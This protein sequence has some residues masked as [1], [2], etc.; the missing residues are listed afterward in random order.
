MEKDRPVIWSQESRYQV[1]ERSFP[2]AVRTYEGLDGTLS[3]AEAHPAD[4]LKTAEPLAYVFHL[5]ELHQVSFSF[6][7]RGT[8][9]LRPRKTSTWSRP[10][11][12]K[13][14]MIIRMPPK[15]ASSYVPR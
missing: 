10:W 14:I 7:L 4:R 13:S 15:T 8:R 2:G 11:G 3:D 9:P 5:K 12:T 1:E 6:G